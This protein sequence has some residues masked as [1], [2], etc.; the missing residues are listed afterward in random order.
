MAAET[1]PGGAVLYSIEGGD[2]TR[3]NRDEFIPEAEV[4]ALNDLEK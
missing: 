1:D 4:G 3:P 2:N